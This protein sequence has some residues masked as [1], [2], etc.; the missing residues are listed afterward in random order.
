MQYSND[1]MKQNPK[2]QRNSDTDMYFNLQTVCKDITPIGTND[3][4]K[5]TINHSEDLNFDY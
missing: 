4:S 1:I 5:F 3:D 2:T